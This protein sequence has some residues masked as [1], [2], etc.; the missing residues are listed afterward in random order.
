MF[1]Q[2]LTIGSVT[3][4]EGGD[5]KYIEL[6]A[7]LPPRFICATSET[8][9]SAKGKCEITVFGFMGIESEDR[10]C[11]D[12]TSIPQAVIG[13]PNSYGEDIIVPC[14]VKV[15][16]SNWFKVLRFAVKAKVDLFKD[17][18]YTRKLTITQKVS[19]GTK[20]ITTELKVVEVGVIQVQSCRFFDYIFPKK[21]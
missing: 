17:A 12:E 15:T 7:T 11:K 14:G 9:A 20:Q 2:V 3:V 5:V 18:N 16:H 1:L 8:L 21:E 6:S 4:S 10:K 13:W 19:V